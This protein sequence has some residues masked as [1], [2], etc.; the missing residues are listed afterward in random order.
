MNWEKKHGFTVHKFNFTDDYE[1]K[2]V[3]TLLE[4]EVSS[5]S[6]KALLYIHGFVDYFFQAELADWANGLGYHFYAL[7]L[8]KYGRSLLPHQKA[9][10]FRDYHEYFEDIDRAVSFIRMEKKQR[11]LVLMGHSTGGLLTSLYAHQQREAHTIDALILNSPFFDFNAPALMKKLVVPLSAGL[12]KI[13]PNIL[14]PEGLKEGY[15]KSIHKDYYGEWDF[16]L[17]LKPIKGFTP[18]LGW[19]HGIKSAQDELHKGLDITCPVL[20]MY[21]D[22]SVPPADYHEGMQT[23]DSVLNVKDIAAYAKNLGSEVTEVEV[24]D[25]LHDLI[26]S[27]K[28]VRDEVYEQ[29]RAFLQKHAK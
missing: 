28:S 23:A 19:I 18:N 21:S 2:V 1:G 9:N 27:R 25:G 6:G 16:D 29:M 7:D 20:V 5:G 10:N 14:S 8:R 15:P 17:N 4:R 12:G 3:C 11:Y 22:K 24:V 13:F 26:L